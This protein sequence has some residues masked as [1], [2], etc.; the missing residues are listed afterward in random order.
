MPII[1]IIYSMRVMLQLQAKGFEFL[2]I[3]PNPQHPEYNCWVYELTD[4]LQNALDEIL[5]GECNDR[6]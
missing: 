6:T 4:E 3:M 2:T 5:G 1:K